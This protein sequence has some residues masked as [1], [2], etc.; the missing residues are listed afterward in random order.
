MKQFLCTLLL[1]A[2]FL[3]LSAQDVYNSSGKPG[4]YKKKEKKGYDPDKLI[5]GAGLNANYAN[6]ALDETHSGSYIQLGV[7][8]KVG[9]KLTEYLSVGVGLGYQYYKEPDFLFKDKVV[10]YHL[11]IFY[12]GIWAKCVVYRPFFV[13]VDFEYDI[14]SMR[15]YKI[16]YDANA[17]PFALVTKRKTVTAACLPVGAGFM[18]PLGGR[19]SFI[20]EAMYDALQADYS[21]YK[22][23]LI[24][25]AG[26]YLGL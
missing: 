5:L 19:T 3:S 8:P 7:S 2:G 18:Q 14:S 6:V 25:R 10:S 12:P 26:I 22:G 23:Q 21:P 4:G 11:N 17:N 9:Y 13:A 15:S 1:C 24:Y 20:I 16:I